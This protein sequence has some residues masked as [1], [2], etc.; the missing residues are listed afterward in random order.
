MW[1]PEGAG[2]H[3]AGSLAGNLA[4]IPGWAIPP[5]GTACD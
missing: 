3:S 5:A 2:Y 4:V 1:G